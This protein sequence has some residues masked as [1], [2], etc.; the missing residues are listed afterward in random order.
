MKEKVQMIVFVLVLG[1]VLT[2]ALVSVDAFTAPYIKANTTKKLHESILKAAGVAFTDETLEEVFSGEM[3]EKVFPDALQDEAAASGEK[4]KFYVSRAGDIV[5]E[6]RGYG[7]QDEIYGV[8]ALAPDMETIKGITIVS[9]KETPGLGGRIGD[10]E[11]LNQ[12]RN[13]KIVPKIDITAEGRASA[14]NEVNGM[15][16]ATMSCNALEE[17]LNKE[18]QKYIPAI[19]ESLK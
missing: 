3:Q 11:F 8:I 10:A 1:S 17:L 19:K 9:Q 14:E 4:R 7:L 16:G 5:F 18:I 6:Y 12:F 13:K 15:T 2:A